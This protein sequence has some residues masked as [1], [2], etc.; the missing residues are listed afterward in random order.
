MVLTHLL[1]SAQPDF[2]YNLTTFHLHHG[3]RNE[4]DSDVEFLMKTLKEWGV[5]LQVEYASVPDYAREK[6]ISIEEAGRILRYQGL[7]RIKEQYKQAL[8]VTGH[9]ADDLAET[10]FYRLLAGVG[11][12]GLEPMKILDGDLVRPLLPFY[13]N[14]IEQYAHQE[15]IKFIVDSTNFDLKYKRNYIRHKLFPELARLNAG[16]KEHLINITRDAAEVDEYLESEVLEVNS[17]LIE[18]KENQ[19]I[20][21]LEKF[22][23]L[24]SVIKKRILIHLFERKN[25]MVNRKMLERIIALASKPQDSQ[26]NLV[27]D[28]LAKKIDK[29]LYLFL[30][31]HS[32]SVGKEKGFRYELT[33]PGELIIPET[34]EILI[35]K[36]GEK[37][38]RE[39]S[40]ELFL[41]EG[42]FHPPLVVRSREK[43]DLIRLRRLKGKSRKIQDI[44]VDK[45][46]ERNQRDWHLLITDTQRIL[47]VVGL[48]K[49]F[50]ENEGQGSGVIITCDRL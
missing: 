35:A 24:P 30:T 38:L 45:K 22:N 4:A 20:I 18:E 32:R 43:G 6:R 25:E 46:I 8:I 14:E 2:G 7:R 40:H 13:R 41:P 5:P 27:K 26:V 9:N 44:F 37:P 48:E 31:K 10:V 33:L 50:L 39:S 21:Q 49:A 1:L 29:K 47:W 36:Y 15:N 17:S 19:F 16:F 11:I 12:R 3:M 34:G 23:L 42:S 28:F